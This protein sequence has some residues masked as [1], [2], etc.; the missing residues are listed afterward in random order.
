MCLSKFSFS[1]TISNKTFGKKQENQA[2]LDK[3]RNFDIVFGVSFDRYHQKL[4]FGEET[5][6]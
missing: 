4:V 6:Q 5:G 1:S 2:K 3:T